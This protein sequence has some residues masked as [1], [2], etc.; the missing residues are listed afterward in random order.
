MAITLDTKLFGIFLFLC[1]TKRTPSSTRPKQ[2]NNV[3][4]VQQHGM[5]NENVLYL[6]ERAIFG[7][8]FALLSHVQILTMWPCL[9]PHLGTPMRKILTIHH[10]QWSLAAGI[11]SPN[12]QFSLEETKIKS[13]WQFVLKGI[14]SQRFEQIL[15]KNRI[16]PAHGTHSWLE[17][18]A[19]ALSLFCIR[20]HKR[21]LAKWIGMTRP[22]EKSF[23]VECAQFQRQKKSNGMTIR[24]HSE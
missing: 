17:C 1:E 4:H 5:Q 21:K 19:Q 9:V 24:V 2:F 6:Q 7:M 20:E 13:H 10:Y 15:T 23:H 22:I 18:D 16:P 3:T 8:Y 11:G 12:W 14:I